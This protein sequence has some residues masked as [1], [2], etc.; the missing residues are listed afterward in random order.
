MAQIV[1]IKEL[2][3]KYEWGWVILQNPITP[4]GY[5]YVTEGEYVFHS[6]LRK[7]CHDELMKMNNDNMGIISFGKNP[8]YANSYPS[9]SLVSV[10][11]E[12]D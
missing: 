9:L 10:V 2:E 6:R 3:E 7:D 4:E 5:A 8:K 11:K 1:T 12:P